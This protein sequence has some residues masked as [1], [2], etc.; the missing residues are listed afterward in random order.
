MKYIFLTI[1]ALLALPAV[2]VCQQTKYDRLPPDVTLET[3]VRKDV[4]NRRGKV[5]SSEVTT[6]EKRLKELKA[7]YRKNVLVDGKG[8]EIRFFEPLCRGVSAGFEEDQKA[9]KE[10]DRE[11]AA[12]R[13]KYTVII[14]YCNPLKAV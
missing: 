6:V 3:E 10:K 1:L 7:R 11:L 12:L 9:Q 13:K 14:L 5:I 8:R 4:L 2:G